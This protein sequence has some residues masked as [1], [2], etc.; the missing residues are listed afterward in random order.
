MKHLLISGFAFFLFLGTVASQGLIFQDTVFTD[1]VSLSNESEFVT[2]QNCRFENIVGDALT[3]NKCG[4]VISDCSF[5]NIAG[6]GIVLDSSEIYL[7]NDTLQNIIGD[8]V[9]AGFSTV[10]VQGCQ[11]SNIEETA[12]Y[13]VFCDLAEVNGCN[14]EDVG[15]GVYCLG[16]L[17]GQLSILNSNILRVNGVPGIANTGSAIWADET[18]LVEIENCTIDSC[19]SYGILLHGIGYLTGS[20]DPVILQGNTISRTNSPGIVG[21]NCPNAIIRANDVSYP[22]SFGGICNCIEWYSGPD[23][24]IENNLL[25][26]ALDTTNQHGNG[27]L[28][29]NSATISR[30]KIHDCTGNGIRYSVQD[31][32]GEVPVLIFNNV[33]HDVGHHP[34]FYEGDGFS[35]MNAP[36]EVII[37]NNTLHA[38]PSGNPQ[39]DAPIGVCCDDTPIEAQG[40]ILIYD[41]VADTATYLFAGLGTSLSEN[42]NLKVS[43][44]IDFV[45]YAGRD[46]HLASFTS[47]AHNFL[48]LGFG[49]P[50]DDFD[51]NPRIGQ[52]DAGAFELIST[53]TI[54]GCANCP[55][56]IPDLAF[57]DY[58]YSVGDI[59]NANLASPTQGVCAVRVQFEH[60]Y[61]GDLNMELI[62]PAGQSVQLVGPT[63]FFGATNFTTWDVGFVACNET[64][65]PD[66]G[67]SPTWNSMQ[68][69]GNGANYT[70]IYYPV[71]GCLE[72]FNV[73]SVIGDWT[74]RVYD[75]Q[76]S[77]TGLVHKFEM[78][79]CEMTGI[80]CQPCSNPPQATF[81]ANLVGDWSVSVQNQTAGSIN[82]YQI[83][84]G[85][86]F[87]ASGHTIPTFHTY[88]DIG[89]F[90]IQ[91]IAINECGADT[92]TQSVLIQ[93][94]LPIAFVIA[95]P[96]IGCAPLKVQLGASFSENVEQWHWICPGGTPSESFEVEPQITYSDPG[97]YPITVVVSNVVGSDTLANLLSVEVLPNLI[98]PSFSIQVIGD[99]IVCTNTTQNALAFWKLNSTDSLGIDTSPQVFEVDSS[100]IYTVVLTV[101]N[102]CEIIKVL[103][104]VSVIIS[105]DKSLEAAG[106]EFALSPNPNDGAFNLGVVS[107]ENAEAR[108]SV[109][110]ALGQ[111]VYAETVQAIEG[112]NMFSISLGELPS[113]LYSLHFGAEKGSVVLRFVVR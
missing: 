59:A 91:L 19:Q 64:A 11:I 25:H 55:L 97:I 62:S 98:N 79:F 110:N 77:D 27:I 17:F 50:N 20:P 24:R 61:I 90:Q 95:E 26:H 108:M 23:A 58:I 84:F 63:G 10:V 40:N 81:T 34:I 5:E 52:H 65:T 16:P 109:L 38:T 15:D 56:A 51:G 54:C 18:G 57:G 1:P 22:G 88:T 42:L 39:Q 80:S 104:N 32:V 103:Q 71:N 48:P 102:D 85:D 96:T 73:G 68:V 106:W 89:V 46:F 67:F 13:F 33:I 111:E 105:G 60:E 21:V 66:P 93:G 87:S 53:D 37:R 75:T 35:S 12:L 41:G 100:G 92:F 76:V 14:I 36:S 9:Y 107:P 44:D 2:F 99:S 78:I 49:L 74:L 30:N 82:Q 6:S 86:G 3:L 8:G 29:T 72:D 7:I 47:A 83:D 113:G 112:R 43:G 45:D 70:G 28:V 69:W 31:S 4:A 101:V 94:A